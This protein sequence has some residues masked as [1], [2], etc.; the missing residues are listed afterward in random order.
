[1]IN[2]NAKNYLTMVAFK[3]LVQPMDKFKRDQQEDNLAQNK[4]I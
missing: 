3:L 2:K 4:I 1:M